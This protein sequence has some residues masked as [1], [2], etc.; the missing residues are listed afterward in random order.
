MIYFTSDT[1]FGHAAILKYSRRPFAT[2]QEHDEGLV[3]RWNAVVRPGDTVYHLGDFTLSN[4]KLI[5]EQLLS[6][7]NGQKF[8]ILGN[9]DRD[10]VRKAS[11]WVK[12]VP[13]HELSIPMTTKQ[14]IPGSPGKQ[15]I[16]L[17]HYRMVVWNKAH[18]GSWALHGHSHGTL[19]VNYNARTFD[20]GVDCWNY[21]PVSLAQVAE[22]MEQHYWIAVDGHHDREM[23]SM[24]AILPTYH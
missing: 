23:P 13:Y 12:V 7:L 1:H 5:V 20:I 2:L 17:F 24:Q 19:P 6:R 22:R 16:C 18:Y 10:P 15:K 11:G 8:L 4:S 14:T 9:H 3:E 21:T